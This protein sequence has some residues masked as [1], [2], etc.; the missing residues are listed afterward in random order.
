MKRP[1]L[2]VS[3][4]LVIVCGIFYFATVANPHANLI[5]GPSV[6]CTYGW[7]APWLHMRFVYATQLQNGKVVQGATTIEDVHID[8]SPLLVSA[9]TA[10]SIAAILPALL[11]VWNR[12]RRA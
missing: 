12:W 2:F 10:V 3:L 7:P 8:W 6:S 1:F 4:F 5:N 9:A 11:M